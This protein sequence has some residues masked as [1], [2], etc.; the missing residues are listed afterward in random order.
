MPGNGK[1]RCRFDRIFC[2]KNIN[3]EEFDLE[4]TQ[5][6]GEKFISD[7]FGISLAIQ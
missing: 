4:G 5:K 1:P 2:S 7:H 3:L 6:T